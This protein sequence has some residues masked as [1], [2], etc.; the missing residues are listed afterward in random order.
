MKKKLMELRKKIDVLN[1]QLKDTPVTDIN[2]QIELNAKIT[3]IKR[4][5]RAIKR[6]QGEH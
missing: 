3:R 1:I 6:T 2:K 5:V 4:Q